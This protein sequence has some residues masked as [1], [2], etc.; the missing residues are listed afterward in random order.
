VERRGPALPQRERVV[1]AALPGEERQGGEARG[2]V[3]DPERSA[4]EP[5]AAGARARGGPALLEGAAARG[6][7]GLPGRLA[8]VAAHRDA[9]LLE[10]LDRQLAADVHDDE[11]VRQGGQ[12]AADLQ[13]HLACPDLLHV[14]GEE[15]LD[16]PRADE[17]AEPLAVGLAAPRELRAAVRERHL[18]AR[19]RGVPRRPM[20]RTTLLAGSG[21]PRSVTT[22]KSPSAPSMPV[23]FT[24]SDTS[25]PVRS[26]IRSQVRSSS[27]FVMEVLRRL[28]ALDDGVLDE[29]HAAQLACDV[30]AGPRGLEDLVHL[31]EIDAALGAAEH[32]PDGP[33]RTLRGAPAV[34][35]AVVR[36]DEPGAAVHDAQDVASGHA[37]RQERL[38]MQTSR[39][40]TGWS[41]RARC[42]PR[43]RF[44]S[45]TAASR[46]ARR[47]RRAA[48]TTMSRSKSPSALP[49]RR[50]VGQSIGL[51]VRVR[52]PTERGA[53]RRYDQGAH[54]RGRPKRSFTA[55]DRCGRAPRKARRSRRGT[56]A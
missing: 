44:S 30:H 35:D 54:P 46:R 12:P 5:L 27:S 42:W 13:H 31:G 40:M 51:P 23:T 38:P 7:A 21:G 15:R 39:S 9:G 18:R 56:S 33:H 14:R 6:A 2:D 45:R 8:V 55:R 10:E 29:P 32:E 20:A 28:E 37:C 50:S 24:P 53:A 49:A 26:R 22:W 1:V 34:A 4:A 48:G 47:L 19:L 36:V 17:R 3:E 16:H 25:M 52:Y 43:R 11:V 41:D